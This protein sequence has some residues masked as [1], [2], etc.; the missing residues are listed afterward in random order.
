MRTIIVNFLKSATDPEIQEV[1][2]R[3]NLNGVRAST[4]TKK[5]AVDLPREDPK[6]LKALGQ[7]PLVEH[8]F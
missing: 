2:E 7:E 1:L 4:L 5:Y 8:V 3:Y 6:M